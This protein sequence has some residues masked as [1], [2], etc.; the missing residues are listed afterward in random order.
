M[1]HGNGMIIS[2]QGISVDGQ[3]E[4]RK[5]KFPQNGLQMFRLLEKIMPTRHANLHGSA[6]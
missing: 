4:H 5:T 3:A 6:A 1:P 2:E